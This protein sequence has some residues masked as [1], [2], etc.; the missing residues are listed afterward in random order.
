[1]PQS[2]DQVLSD[3]EFHQ[4][5]LGARLS[6][7]R[8]YP[9][10]SA[11]SP[12]DQGGLVA[13]AQQQ[14]VGTTAAV[15]KPQ[16]APD[17]G[18]WST[19]GHDAMSIPGAVA[20]TA[21]DVGK[22]ALN[23]LEA[24]N[25][26]NAVN[27]AA[28]AGVNQ[29][30]KAKQE[31]KQ[32]NYVSGMGRTIAAALPV[33][34]PAAAQAGEELGGGQPGAG[35]AHALEL[36]GP[37]AYSALG[38]AGA[39]PAAARIPRNLE[40]VNNPVVDQA[41]A[42]V[43]P[44][45]RMTPGQRT[46]Q[47]GL[48]TS[49]RNLKNMP[50]TATEAEQFYQGAQDDI[51]AEGNRLV[52]QQGG[53]ATNPYGAG[54]AVQQ[55]LKQRIQNRK[56]F[57]DELYDS[58]RKDTA[59]NLKPVQ[60]GVTPPSSVLGPNGQPYGGAPVFSLM[61]T[62]VDLAPIRQQL[63][64]VYDDLAANLTP[65]KQASSPAFTALKNLM[66]RQDLQQ[67]PAMDFDKFLGALKSITRNGQSGELSSQS[68]RLAGQVI[69]AGE[70]QLSQ[71]LSGAGPKVAST[72]K[73][74]RDAVKDYHDTNSFLTD[75]QRKPNEPY[76]PAAIYDNLVHGGD[77]VTN[78]LKMLRETADQQP[79]THRNVIATIGRTY[80]QEMMDKATREGGWGR[81][82]GVDADWNR[83][84]PEAKEIL[85]GPAVQR[86]DDFFLAA[87]KLTPA[88][89]SPTADRLSALVSYGD[90]GAAIA[91]FVGGSAMGHPAV[92]ALGAAATLAKTRLQP[93]IL[94]KLSFKPAGAQLLQQ[95]LTVPI[96]S[97]A[98]NRAMAGLT[99]MAQDKPANT[100]EAMG[101]AIAQGNQ[102]Q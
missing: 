69:S 14:V 49:E 30:Q 68:Q 100:A 87:K 98:F 12:K 31:F 16:G 47:L 3:P 29:F 102:Q 75:L 5:P 65:V 80:L 99:A 41:I 81:S 40:N 13:H 22:I 60:T 44:R 23:P 37:S 90:V 42:S 9:E 52:Q 54:Q 8:T 62:P 18:L 58:V 15:N 95:V 36:L 38:E 70:G 67:M 84:G 93:A 19:L 82:A 77:R 71:A 28:Q 34:G 27:Q 17:P 92:G 45:V 50:G 101:R 21:V 53:Q 7:L 73:Q 56:S 61:E 32:G 74:A 43:A 55:A 78:T 97:P 24:T 96:N 76:E 57:A 88:V 59:A 6:V 66:E 89:G 33:V 35:A 39:L 20:K 85:F 48:Q 83:L 72:L 1:M 10:F 86:L 4:Q 25:P 64:P 79:Y 51:A 63:Q 11:L 94:A 91:E 46:G 2:I 26:T